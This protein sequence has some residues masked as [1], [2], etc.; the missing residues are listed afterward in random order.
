M[1]E[2]LQ[3]II[4]LLRQTF[5]IHVEGNPLHSTYLHDAI[6]NEG[7]KDNLSPEDIDEGQRHKHRLGVEVV[8]SAK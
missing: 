1:I 2:W 8:N 7:C 5:S 3:T 6:D 4:F